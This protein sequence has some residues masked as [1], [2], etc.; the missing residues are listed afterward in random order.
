L[1]INSLPKISA[2]LGVDIATYISLGPRLAIIEN[3]I[4][5]IRPDRVCLLFVA[6]IVWGC[7]PPAL[8]CHIFLCGSFS[9]LIFSQIKFYWA[10]RLGIINFN[11]GHY[12]TK[13]LQ[14]LKDFGW[15][16]QSR[17]F[18]LCLLYSPSNEGLVP[19][20]L[21]LFPYWMSSVSPICGKGMA[22]GGFFATS[23]HKL[24]RRSCQK[25]CCGCH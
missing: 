25:Y 1:I 14:M 6:R 4:S 23:Q 15:G 20:I 10:Y 13:T 11:W 17:K 21:T 2:R 9:W 18:L 12:H 5:I 8:K 3:S 22:T 16:Y 19:S 24:D 7:W